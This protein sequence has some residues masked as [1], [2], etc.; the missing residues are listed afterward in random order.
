M[1]KREEIEVEIEKLAFGGKGLAR[2]ENRV[3]FVEKGIPG[4]QAIIRIRKIKSN[5]AEARLIRLIK[6]SPLRQIAP[7]AH[8]GNCGGCKWQNLDYQQQLLFKREQVL[9]SLEHIAGVMPEMIHPTLPSPL[10]FEYR[11][12]T[13]FSFT[14]SRWLTPEELGN[15]ELEKGFAL[16][17][18]VPGAFDRVMH[19]EKCWLQDETMNQILN[20]SQQFLERSGLPVFDLKSH[21]GLLRFLVLRKSFA[22]RNYMVNVVTFL[23]AQEQ[24]WEFVQQLVEKFPQVASV[25]NAVNR[26]FAQIAFSEEEYLLSGDNSLTEKLGEFEFEISANSFFQTNPRQAENLYSIVQKYVGENHAVIWDLFSGTGTIALFLS[27]LAQKVVGF[28]LV[29]SA[30]RDA[31][32]NCLRNKVRNCEFLAGDIRQNIL[33]NRELP[34]VIVCDP[35]RSGMHPDVVKAIVDIRPEKIVYVSCNPATMA[36]DLKPMLP[37]YKV[38]E[39]QPVDMFPH[40][41]HIESVVKLEKI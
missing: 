30:V 2:L 25:V 37:F 32:Q 8:F 31:F 4:D 11:N 6:P 13:E 27:H 35:P 5:Y 39:V 22:R 19:I 9:E 15:P 28:E 23:P 14:H 18:H 41:Y 40:T 24:L 12:K 34:Q 33:Q 20:F 16:G 36:R 21:E 3:V 17:F 38:L 10:V 29:E 7:C 1:K 26:R